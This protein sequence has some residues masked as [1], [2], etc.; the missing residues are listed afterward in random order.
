[1]RHAN[2]PIRFSALEKKDLFKAWILTSIAF[3][4]F[5]LQGQLSKVSTTGFLVIF[6][7]AGAT[8]GVGFIVHELCHKFAAHHF[9]VHGEFRANTMMLYMSIVF[10]LMGFIIAAPG[11]VYMTGHIT[12]RQNGIISAAGPASNIVLA[13][14][15]LPLFLMEG[16][17]K[18]IGYFGL[19]INAILA[20]FNMIPFGNFDGSKVLPWSKPV[21]FTMVFLAGILI[22]LAYSL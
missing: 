2:Q 1:M 16:L 10:A 13:A 11:A 5:F 14:L 12:K 19:L 7:L 22:V 17:P 20:G 6:V 18:T 8:A 4:V 3:T 21:Y 9:H 15:F